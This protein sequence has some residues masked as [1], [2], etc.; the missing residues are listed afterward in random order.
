MAAKAATAKETPIKLS[1]IEIVDLELA[2]QGDTP[3]L[4]HN[5]SAKAK[6]EMLDKQTKQPKQAKQAKNPLHDYV[7][8]L[9]WMSAK[10]ALSDVNE[11]TLG[12]IIAA[13]RFGFPAS[14]IK[15]AIDTEVGQA[16]GVKKT[17]AR[18][19]FY[20]PGTVNA[21]GIQLVEILGKPCMREDMVKVGGMTKVADLRYRAEF[22]DWSIKF[23]MRFNSRVMSADQL[24]SLVSLAG[25][26]CGIGEWRPQKSGQSG[27][28]RA[29]IAVTEKK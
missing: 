8:S 13:G 23:V 28:F 15:N 9:Y 10:P 18:A 20:I 21:D 19:T 3:L 17:D 6:K 29:L 5:W 4:V 27:M 2:I 25:F 1:P 24:V 22:R 26:G 16:D 11:E 14:G 7:E 12:A